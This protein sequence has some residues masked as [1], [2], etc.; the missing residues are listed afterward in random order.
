VDKP[1]ELGNAHV[2]PNSLSRSGRGARQLEGMQM[3]PVY[4]ANC[5]VQGPHWVSAETIKYAF[6]LCTPSQNDCEAKWQHLAGLFPI[7][8]EVFMNLVA[9]AQ[10]E[11]EGRALTVEETAEALKDEHHYLSKL[12]RDRALFAA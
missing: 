11:N 4:C 12:A 2:L 8:D 6:Y 10:L 5:G 1:T 3:V 9:Q 7:P